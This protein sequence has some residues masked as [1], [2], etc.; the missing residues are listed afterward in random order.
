MIISDGRSAKKRITALESDEINADKFNKLAGPVTARLIGGGEHWIETLDVG[1]GAM[2][3]DVSGQIDC[4]HF[5]NVDVLIDSDLNKHDP[6]DF[7]N[8]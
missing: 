1:T 6:D 5:S 4:M 3:V 2:R 8:D 7:W